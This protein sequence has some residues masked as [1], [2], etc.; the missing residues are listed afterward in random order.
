MPSKSHPPAA[1]DAALPHAPAADSP[2]SF[3]RGLEQLE[4]IVRE[5]ERGDLALEES[6]A[7]F[8]RGVTL[9]ESC[10]RQLEAAETR[11]EVLRSQGSARPEASPAAAPVADMASG[12][13]GDEDIPF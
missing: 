10:R 12:D 6:I 1:K 3:E 11:I 2:L 9:G 7:L 4:Q 13:H 8:E 5:L